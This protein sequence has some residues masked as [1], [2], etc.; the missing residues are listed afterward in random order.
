MNQQTIQQLKLYIKAKY[1]DTVYNLIK[2]YNQTHNDFKL[3]IC[4]GDAIY[5]Y[6]NNEDAY[7]K[8]FD[9]KVVS[10]QFLDWR[11]FYDT[12][13]DPTG[14][15]MLN[16]FNQQATIRNQFIQDLNQELILLIPNI[17]N[18]N[19]ELLS[20][21]YEI[22]DLNFRYE[23]AYVFGILKTIQELDTLMLDE[24]EENRLK[25]W[26]TF[27]SE[28][29]QHNITENSSRIS[30]LYTC[31]I[32]NL[33]SGHI[34]T[35]EEGLIDAV[36]WSPIVYEPYL[37]NSIMYKILLNNNNI[38]ENTMSY[39]VDEIQRQEDIIIYRNFSFV[40]NNDHLAVISIG[41]C[42]WDTIRMANKTIHSYYS[43]PSE[44]NKNY[45]KKYAKKYWTIINSLFDRLKC[46]PQFI[47]ACQTCITNP[48]TFDEYNTESK[49][50]IKNKL[51]NLF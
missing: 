40:E 9:V 14:N 26:S 3:V 32:R 39:S 11:M 30:I 43:N 36:I 21:G 38:T 6:I 34:E 27:L 1:N 51:V 25:N 47:D 4:G 18:I 8:D 7:T 10:S 35:I 31:R 20:R 29:I 24:I 15:N 50:N 28:N 19:L 17:L 5:Y 45:S 33:I 13:L 22:L 48:R 2:R 23:T 16:I 12:T 42:I 41:F 37:Y 46:T 49:N 44:Y